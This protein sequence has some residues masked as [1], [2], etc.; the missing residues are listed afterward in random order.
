[1]GIVGSS[2]ISLFH[3]QPI[4][5]NHHSRYIPVRDR[6]RLHTDGLGHS[7]EHGYA[8]TYEP[9]TGATGDPAD[10]NHAQV[11]VKWYTFAMLTWGAVTYVVDVGS[12]VYATW[13]YGA[14]GY[15]AAWVVMLTCTLVPAVL[16]GTIDVWWRVDDA[17]AIVRTRGQMAWLDA[18]K[19]ALALVG[20]APVVR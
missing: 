3:R 11:K 5:F 13:H 12:D 9:S 7:T 18:G 19:I 6:E 10:A 15:T 1:M 14:M 2:V 4:D 16:V 20:F 8:K 17:K